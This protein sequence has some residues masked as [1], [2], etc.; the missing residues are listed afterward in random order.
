[1]YRVLFTISSTIHYFIIIFL[2]IAAFATCFNLQQTRKEIDLPV[3]SFYGSVMQVLFMA[4]G[5]FDLEFIEEADSP[6][7][8]SIFFFCFV[9]FVML[10]FLIILI[11]VTTESYNLC[12]TRSLGAWRAEQARIILQKSYLLPNEESLKPFHNPKWLHILA[13]VGTIEAFNGEDINESNVVTGHPGLFGSGGAGGFAANCNCD[14]PVDVSGPTAKFI[15]KEVD[16]IQDMLSELNNRIAANK[17]VDVDVLAEKVAERLLESFKK[18]APRSPRLPEGPIPNV[19][20][21]TRVLEPEPE[22]DTS[23]DEDTIEEAPVP[24][25]TPVAKPRGHSSIRI[26]SIKTSK[27]KFSRQISN[28]TNSDDE[29]DEIGRQYRKKLIAETTIL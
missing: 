15:S 1:M 11:S 3:D 12:Y 21:N 19:Y 26:R 14:H 17:C 7:F 23:S 5:G 29:N 16:D 24:S 18:I 13:P 20:V 9:L 25:P 8:T 2:A 28:S 22:K 27:K 6:L 10:I 4:T